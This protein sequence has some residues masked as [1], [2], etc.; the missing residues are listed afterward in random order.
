[1]S[2]SF[3]L[4]FAPAL[5]RASI[6]SIQPSEAATWMGFKKISCGE[7]FGLAP[8]WRRLKKTCLFPLLMEL[9]R[10]VSSPRSSSRL[11][12]RARH[13]STSADVVALNRS[14]ILSQNNNDRRKEGG[15]LEAMMRKKAKMKMK[16]KMK[17]KRNDFG[18]EWD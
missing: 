6:M 9:M 18:D 11:S 8:C 3:S 10:G 12:P 4:M 16:K 17:K 15:R 14:D 13:S 2:L 1:M 7:W 5:T